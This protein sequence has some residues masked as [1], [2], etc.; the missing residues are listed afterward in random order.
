MT[1]AFVGLVVVVLA[2]TAQ[3]VWRADA[4]RKERQHLVHLSVARTPAEA[5]WLDRATEKPAKQPEVPDED[6]GWELA[7]ERTVGT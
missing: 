2:L 3:M 6:R 7:G 5:V 1:I 4:D